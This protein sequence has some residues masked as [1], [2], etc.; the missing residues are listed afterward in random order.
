MS[1][2]KL[3]KNISFKA[4]SIAKTIIDDFNIADEPNGLGLWLD[5]YTL[6]NHK[7]LM[8][9]A[10]KCLDDNPSDTEGDVIKQMK[11]IIPQQYFY[12]F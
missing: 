11:K 7:A 9:F 4:K 12:N 5:A 8:V 6:S 3:N 10:Q 2:L 1:E